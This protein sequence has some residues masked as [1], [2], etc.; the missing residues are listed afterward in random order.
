MRRAFA[1]VEATGWPFTAGVTNGERA[2]DRRSRGAVVR[3]G[4]G[5]DAG[6]DRGSRCGILEGLLGYGGCRVV[7]GKLFGPGVAIKN[8]GSR[9]KSTGVN[10]Q[11]I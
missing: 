4:H 11:P 8:Y 3:L 2:A 10:H 9:Q 6:R 1:A 5:R 7:R